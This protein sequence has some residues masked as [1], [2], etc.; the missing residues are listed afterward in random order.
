M[1]PASGKKRLAGWLRA[2]LLRVLF[3]LG[4]LV[5]VEQEA[6]AYTD[7]GTGAL[8]WQMLAVGFV[9][10]LVYARKFTAWFKRVN[11]KDAKV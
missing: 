9:G 6:S 2:T 7:P 4:L 8:I 11:K 3:V 1:V 5:A 10:L